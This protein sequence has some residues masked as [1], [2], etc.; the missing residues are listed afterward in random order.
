MQAFHAD[1][2]EGWSLFTEEWLALKCFMRGWRC[3]SGDDIL[4]H[5]HSTRVLGLSPLTSLDSPIAFVKKYCLGGD[6]NC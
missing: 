5:P 4:P 6:L 2:K 3:F 1:V